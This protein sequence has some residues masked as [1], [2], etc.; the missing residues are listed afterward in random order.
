MEKLSQ[1]RMLGVRERGSLWGRRILYIMGLPLIGHI[2]FGVIDRGTNVLQVRPSTLCFHNCIFCSVDAGPGSRTRGSEFLV[3]PDLLVEWVGRVALVKGGGLEALLDG[4][5]EPLT[6]PR[7]ADIIARLKEVPGVERVALETHGGSLSKSLAKLL[8]KAG[9][10]RINLSVDAIN[11]GLARRLVGAEWYDVG[12]VLRMAEWIIRETGI[13]VVLTPVVVPGYNEGEMKALIEWARRVGAGRKSGWPTGVLIQKYEVHRYGRK[14]RL[15]GSPWSWQRFYKWL[16]ELERETGY[17]LLVEPRE[18]G[19]EPRPS[20][21]KPFSQGD[22][23]RGYIASPG[24]HR[25][26]VLV[27]DRGWRRVV[28]VYPGPLPRELGYGA[29]VRVRIVRDKDNIYIGEL[30]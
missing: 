26:E 23:V 4:V 7:I 28:A 16:R 17:R 10:D 6:H 27:V 13:D 19:M 29:E 5:G 12:R 3:D 2:A 8:D 24:W 11:P 18:I 9:L 30:Y 22:L 15:K 25:G 21:E 20:V 1:A 14:P